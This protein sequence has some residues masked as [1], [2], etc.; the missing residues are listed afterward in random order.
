MLIVAESNCCGALL[1][2]ALLDHSVERCQALRLKSTSSPFL[3]HVRPCRDAEVVLVDHVTVRVR[4]KYRRG[5]VVVLGYVQMLQPTTIESRGFTYDSLISDAFIMC[6]RIVI[7]PYDIFVTCMCRLLICDY[8]IYS[9]TAGWI[10]AITRIQRSVVV[11]K[12]R[13]CTI[14]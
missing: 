8:S 14:M 13:F 10:R 1:L 4:R 3:A 6:C 5:E 7:R 11:H 2:Y 12:G 9:M